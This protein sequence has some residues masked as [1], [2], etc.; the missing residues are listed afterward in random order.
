VRLQLL[1]PNLLRAANPSI[2]PL[3]EKRPFEAFEISKASRRAP[4]IRKIS[5][6]NSR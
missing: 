6:P 1:K 3:K 5:S 4:A 2:L